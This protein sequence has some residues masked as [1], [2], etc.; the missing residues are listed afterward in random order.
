MS[1][2]HRGARCPLAHRNLSFERAPCS[3]FNC[4]NHQRGVVVKSVSAEIPGCAEKNFLQ[5]LCTSISVIAKQPLQTL[6][7]E[8]LAVVVNGLAKTIREQQQS[9]AGQEIDL[10]LHVTAVCKAAEH[11]ASGIELKTLAVGVN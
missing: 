6:L 11:T 2:D 7:A 4:D 9:I 5:L 3:L 8:L 1:A 10:A